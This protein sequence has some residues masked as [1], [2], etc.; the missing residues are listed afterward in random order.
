LAQEA[1]K[2]GRIG[3]WELDVASGVLYWDAGLRR[4]MEVAESEAMTLERARGFYSE[5]SN[6]MLSRAFGAALTSAVPYD[7]E[8]EVITARGNRLWVR[9]V[10]R[11]THRR[12]KLK[13]LVGVVADVTERRRLAEFLSTVGDQERA[14]IGADL[15]DGLGQQLTGIAFLLHGLAKR[16]QLVDEGLAAELAKLSR[17]AS[18]SVKGVRDIAHGLLPLELRHGDLK[19]VLLA[20]AKV[21]RRASGVRVTVRFCGKEVYHPVGRVAEHLYR[22]AQE[23]V[24]NALKHGRPKQ[25]LLTVYGRATKNALVVLDDGVGIDNA[26]AIK[27]A[28]GCMRGAD[29]AHG[30]LGCG[31]GLQIM[32]YRARALGGLLNVRQG[33]GGGTRVLCVVPREGE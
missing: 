26:Y 25:V 8:L 29:E 18:S 12:G 3:A 10:C 13:S 4:I 23:A 30:A 27:D 33:R 2:V 19:G 31:M 1:L 5:S 28:E 16:V 32:R 9:E 20:M 24:T 22:I 14:R 11:V 6:I 15:H 17:L 21:T 7:L